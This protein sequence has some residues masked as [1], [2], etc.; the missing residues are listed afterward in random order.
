MKLTNT[1][2]MDLLQAIRTQIGV[3]REKGYNKREDR[4]CDLYARIQEEHLKDK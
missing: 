3:D 4:L 1:D 2:L